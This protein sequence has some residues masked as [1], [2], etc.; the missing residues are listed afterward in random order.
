[1]AN[2]YKNT[3][4]LNPALRS[5]GNMN[6]RGV[7]KGGTSDADKKARYGLPVMVSETGYIDPSLIEGGSVG[8]GTTENRVV[9]LINDKLQPYNNG[10]E[11]K[12]D[13]DSK[14]SKLELSE[15]IK[16]QIQQ[17]I[18]V[19]NEITNVI[20]DKLTPYNNGQEIKDDI[21]G[22]ASKS[23]LPDI[24]KNQLQQNT[25]IK[26]EI[27][28]VIK[29]QI[30]Q[31]SEVKTEITNI[32]G[33][34]LAPYANGQ[35]IKNE[36]NEKVNTTDYEADFVVFDGEEG[37]TKGEKIKNYIDNITPPMPENVI[38]KTDMAPYGQADKTQTGTEIENAIGEKV[39]T[40]TY[41]SDFATF[42]SEQGSTIGEKI[43]NAITGGTQGSGVTEEKLSECLSPY[44]TSSADITEIGTKIKADTNSKVATDKFNSEFAVFDDQTGNTKGEKIKAYIDDHV[45]DPTAILQAD[46]SPYGQGDKAQT[47]AEIQAAIASA[48]KTDEQIK[49]LADEKITE[50]LQPYNSGQE[51]KNEIDTKP[52][53][54]EVVAVSDM[55]PFGTTNK[56]YIGT[57]IVAKIEDII[58]ENLGEEGD[59]TVTIKDRANS[60]TK[61]V[62]SQSMSPYSQSVG[63]INQIGSK[64]KDDVN[65]KVN[66]SD[67]DADFNNFDSEQGATKGAKIQSY[68]NK[69]LTGGLANKVDISAMSP[70]NGNPQQIGTAIENAINAATKTDEQIKD[71]AKQQITTEAQ[72]GGVID[73][74]IDAKIGDN[75]LEK[76]DLAPYGQ[77]DKTQIGAE[78]AAAIQSAGG[79]HTDERIKELAEEKI[80]ADVAGGGTID[81]AISNKLTTEKVLRQGDLAPYGATEI[82]QTG[83]DIKAAIDAVEAKT[84]TDQ[85]I[86]ELA[87]GQI[88]LNAVVPT[89]MGEFYTDD[90]TKIGENIKNAILAA[91]GGGGG[92][93]D[94]A[95][96]S[97]KQSD[98][99]PYGVADVTQAGADI[100][101]GI[102]TA[103]TNAFAPYTNGQSISDEQELQNVEFNKKIN[104]VN[105]SIVPTIKD[106]FGYNGGFEVKK[107]DNI[108]SANYI[109]SP[110]NLYAFIYVKGNNSYTFVDPKDGKLKRLKC[111]TDTIEEIAQLTY[112]ASADYR[113]MKCYSEPDFIICVFAGVSG[114]SGV[115]AFSRNGGQTW[116]V[117]TYQD[118]CISGNSTPFFFKDKNGNYYL[119]DSWR[120]RTQMWDSKNLRLQVDD[121]SAS[122]YAENVGDTLLDTPGAPGTPYCL[123]NDNIILPNR[124][125]NF[126]KT[127]GAKAV[128]NIYN[129]CNMRNITPQNWNDTGTEQFKQCYLRIVFADG[130]KENFDG[131][132]SS[133]MYSMIKIGNKLL[134]FGAKKVADKSYLAMAV[135][136][137]IHDHWDDPLTPLEFHEVTAKGNKL[138]G[139]TLAAGFLNLSNQGGE[140][141]KNGLSSYE[142]YNYGAYYRSTNIMFTP[143]NDLPI[144]HIEADRY[145]YM[146]GMQNQNENYSG[147][148]IPIGIKLDL[149][150]HEVTDEPL[151]FATKEFPTQSLPYVFPCCYQ[152]NIEC[153]KKEGPFYQII[154]N[155]YNDNSSANWYYVKILQKG[156]VPDSFQVGDI[157]VT[158]R[159]MGDSWLECDGSTFTAES[160][161][162]LAEIIKDLTLPTGTPSFLTGGT[163]TFK[164]YI[165][166]K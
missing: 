152:Y 64:I 74:A 10:V 115:N 150:K 145:V 80:V 94:P 124:D 24:I 108:N 122:L 42:A 139:K 45:G 43:R 72:A 28:N 127:L 51:I 93:G 46:M 12:A 155:V 44:S 104:D 82:S 7:V 6:V 133:W 136:D 70:Y 1:M 17:N 102:N 83:A 61:T 120:D 165:K 35:E 110:L 48:G 114:T 134:A 63:D 100:Q 138:N 58:A 90:K 37:A 56:Q 126:Y 16:N 66:T 18:E 65:L 112:S 125:G 77:T 98:L 78:I 147:N 143:A 162:L 135:C 50:K 151:K 99:A 158:C 34:K 5:I 25:E 30:Q 52:N 159:K 129:G 4:T 142:V 105:N 60:V 62:L 89:D 22:K 140:Y 149:K 29:E 81:T 14:V 132:D 3:Q 59:I 15:E 166:A 148:P 146:I 92:G 144:I 131:G 67:Y 111:D 20:D 33:D 153:Y 39:A 49:Q 47:G 32:I 55:S 161:P 130:R 54:D 106:T 40:T 75:L 68:I 9:E 38:E 117:F 85:E 79:G 11:I 97:V 2:K 96:P 163:T 87:D 31:G 19:K 116:S 118:S 123:F 53:A 157:M 88:E 76:T 137:D 164:V 69:E 26:N 154:K 8:G 13:I 141:A 71:L 84:K 57:E 109:S 95:N 23:E 107:A 160:Y 73:T 41:E 113:F 36:V 119:H 21:D 86:K 103:I 27:S 156:G 128:G 101:N 91:G 121:L